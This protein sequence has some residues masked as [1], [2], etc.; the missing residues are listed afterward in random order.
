M[1][2]T[3]SVLLLSAFST[4][5]AQWSKQSRF[6]LNLTLFNRLPLHADVALLIGDFTSL[7]LLEVD[8]RAGGTLGDLA[9][10]LQARLWEDLEHRYFG[11]VE[12]V[13][14]MNTRRGRQQAVIMPVVFTSALGL[15]GDESP[16]A[17]TAPPGGAGTS[18]RTEHG[19]TQTPQTWLDHQVFEESGDVVL[20]W[21]AVE[22][23]DDVRGNELV[24]T[25]MF[26]AGLRVFP[27]KRFYCR[28]GS[29]EPGEPA[30]AALSAAIRR[31]AN[32]A[33]A[34]A[35]GR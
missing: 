1:G 14:E 26:P 25:E 22:G 15:A 29:P 23:H 18:V 35:G 19:I 2:V 3:P 27:A 16:E 34:P 10:A 33:A 17:G 12:V 6:T 32:G 20:V 11:G 9:R 28:D 13:R 21:D 4:V 24:L 30:G 31:A 7:T 8:V 5:V